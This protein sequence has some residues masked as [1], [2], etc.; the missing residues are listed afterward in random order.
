MYKT[1]QNKFQK[2]GESFPKVNK[3]QTFGEISLP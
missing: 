3:F 2:L 1:A